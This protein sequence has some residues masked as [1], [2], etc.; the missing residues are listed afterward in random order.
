MAKFRQIWSPWHWVN[1]TDRS[2][3]SD[4]NVFFILRHLWTFVE[5]IHRCTKSNKH[6]ETGCGSVGKVVA[7]N[8]RG[9]R[10]KSYHQQKFILNIYCQLYWKDENKVK[11]TGNG[12]FFESKHSKTRHVI[13][14]AP[15]EKKSVIA[16]LFLDCH[17][18]DLIWQFIGLWA[19][20]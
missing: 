5:T 18:C 11:E 1:R 13:S 8:C 4:P 17:Q 2:I 3:S 19:T 9:P 6:S 15:E 12:P 10:F 20:F 14:S 16:A 7:S